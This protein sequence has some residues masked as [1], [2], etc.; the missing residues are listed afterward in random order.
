MRK[1]WETR[2]REEEKRKGNDACGQESKGTKERKQ[3][4]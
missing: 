1:E 3:V 4:G 2:K